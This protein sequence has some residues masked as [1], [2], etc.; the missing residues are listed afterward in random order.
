MIH[1]H[2]V[3]LA[4]PGTK[5]L[6][7]YDVNL[8]IR[9][10]E[11][12]FLVGPSG[13]GKSSLLA[14]VL[15]RLL[16]TQGAVY[17]DGTNLRRLRGN[18]IAL[19]RR[20]VGVVFQDH[21]LLPARTV[22]ENLAFVLRVQGVP[23]RLWPERITRALR[24]VGLVHKRRAFPHQLSVGEAQRVAVARALL[25]EPKVLLADEP[26]GNLDRENAL[27]VL[28]LFKLAHAKGATVVFATHAQEL[29]RAYPQRV[30]A[31]RAGQV[32][33]DRRLG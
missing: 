10:G 19:Y 18:R 31:L 21:R 25:P 7:L 32:V 13:A 29:V 33:A 26:T 2:R 30:V 15:R 9:R 6:A 14:L 11:F 8:E 27:A 3:S 1:L 24:T 5:T 4:Y 12:V 28:E 22:E 16:P 17:V 20:Q 23:R